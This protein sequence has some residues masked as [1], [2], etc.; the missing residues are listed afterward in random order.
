MALHIL[1]LKVLESQNR[2]PEGMEPEFEFLMELL[3]RGI[4]LMLLLLLISTQTNAPATHSEP[5]DGD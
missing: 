1:R 3:W 2:P 4:I 5:T